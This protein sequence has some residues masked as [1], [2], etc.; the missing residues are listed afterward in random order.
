MRFSMRKVLAAGAALA[1][2]LAAWFLFA[3]QALGG[4]VAYLVV[5]G[6]SMK[7][8]LS[9]GDL[10]VVRSADGYA[11]G[12]VVAYRSPVANRT[13]VHRILRAE[14]GRFVLKGDA[15]PYPDAGRPEVAAID[16]KLWFAVPYVGSGLGWLAVPIHAAL[17]G[18]L[19]VLLLSGGGGA[20]V[21]RRKRRRH[22][23][24]PAEASQPAPTS[25]GTPSGPLFSGRWV[26]YALLVTGVAALAIAALGLIAFS[27]ETTTEL[28]RTVP[29]RESGS[30]AYWADVPPGVVYSD[31]RVD[32]G[33]P[34]FLRLVG[35]LRTRFEYRL[36]TDAALHT[37]GRIVLTAIVS[38]ADGWQQR[39]DLGPPS[40][41]EG[42]FAAASGTL[43]LHRVQKLIADVERATGVAHESYTVALAPSVDLDGRLG[44]VDISDRF[45]PALKFRLDRLTLTL[46]ENTSGRL[47]PVRT[48][49]AQAHLLRPGAFSALGAEIRVTALRRITVAV[50][51]VLLFVFLLIA[52]LRARALRRGESFRIEARY[53]HLLVPVSPSASEA[54]GPLVEVA[55]MEGLSRLAEPGNRP[56]LHSER[57]GTHS[58]FVED[59]GVVYRYSSGGA[60]GTD[61]VHDEEEEAAA[62]LRLLRRQG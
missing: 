56:I 28:D 38:D 57:L 30:F 19:L 35:E 50:G 11:A 45:T 5:E 16:G 10:V 4:S 7:P 29:Y 61:A 25:F 2:A 34:V 8:G 18:G 22:S 62:R 9:G 1:A 60:Q 24:F 41:F 6:T 23:V 39:I 43:D 3:P 46:D 54:L 44:G 13:F 21:Q 42:G 55:T 47:A 14:E 40:D 36:R 58:Y 49:S 26:T 33:E 51:L 52:V 17:V 15:N 27:R 32:T 48:R 20:A 12:D 37:S 31:G 53:G 59:G